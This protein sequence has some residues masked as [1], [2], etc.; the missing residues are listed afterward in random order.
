MGAPFGTPPDF[1]RDGVEHVVVTFTNRIVVRVFLGELNL[2][3]G[4]LTARFTRTGR[5]SHGQRLP[6]GSRAAFRRHE[7][8][9]RAVPLIAVQLTRRVACNQT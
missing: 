2:P 7:L 9:Q 4:T 8:I 3:L 5:E 6:Q 1:K